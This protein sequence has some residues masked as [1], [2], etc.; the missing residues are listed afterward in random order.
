[1]CEKPKGIEWPPN[2]A[3]VDD[4]SINAYATLTARTA[5]PEKVRS[6]I[7]LFASTPA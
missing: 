6:S 7:R 5:A 1:M 3:I 4:E 2:V